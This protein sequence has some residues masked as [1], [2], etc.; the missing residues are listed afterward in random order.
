M[1]AS[2]EHSEHENLSTMQIGTLCITNI[3]NIDRQ[4]DHNNYS[5]TL[6]ITLPY[7]LPGL[8]SKY[9]ID[10]GSTKLKFNEVECDTL[11]TSV[12]YTRNETIITLRIGN[13]GDNWQAISPMYDMQTEYTYVSNSTVHPSRSQLKKKEKESR[14]KHK[15]KPS[16][17]KFKKTMRPKRKIGKN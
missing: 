3:S 16:F 9:L 2:I 7:K 6:T 15:K 17:S 11:V 5:Y 13:R 10:C 14:K 12:R 4:T 1:P 8:Q